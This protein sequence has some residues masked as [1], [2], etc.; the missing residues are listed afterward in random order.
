[1]AKPSTKIQTAKVQLASYITCHTAVGLLDNL[2]ELVGLAFVRNLSLQHTKCTALISNVI[3]PYILKDLLKGI[4]DSLYSLVINKS[5]NVIT[6][7]QLC[8]VVCYFN[9]SLNKKKI[10]IFGLIGYAGRNYRSNHN[11]TDSVSGQY[12]SGFQEVCRY[13]N[14]QL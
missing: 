13:Q 4:R 2:G 9:I 5:T 8:I 6:V 3:N 10:N 14:G 7:K 1:M 11:N 12:R